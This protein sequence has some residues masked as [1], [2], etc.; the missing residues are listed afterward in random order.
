V[1]FAGAGLVLVVF[2][3]MGTELF[4]AN[5]PTKIFGR[6]SDLV[7]NNEEVRPSPSPIVSLSF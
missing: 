7:R 3:S 6:A 5:S 2:Y 4:A 1:I